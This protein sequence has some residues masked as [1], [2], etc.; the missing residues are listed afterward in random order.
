M[1]KMHKSILAHTG[2]RIVTANKKPAAADMQ[3]F[4]EIT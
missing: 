4:R 1:V 2:N 3:T